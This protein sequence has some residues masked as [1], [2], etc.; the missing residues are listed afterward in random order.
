MSININNSVANINGTPGIM[1]G[2]LTA[3]PLA[4]VVAYGTIYIATDFQAI[5][6]N[7]NGT[8]VQVGKG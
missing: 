6:T 1:T 3:R 4:T 7:L 5:Y 8:W 2:T